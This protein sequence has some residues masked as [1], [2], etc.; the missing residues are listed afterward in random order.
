LYGETGIQFVN[1]GTMKV[2]KRTKLVSQYF[3]EG[4]DFF[5]SSYGK[6]IIQLTWRERK[7]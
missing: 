6:E 3:G 7:M 4:A 1:L 2:T 5:V